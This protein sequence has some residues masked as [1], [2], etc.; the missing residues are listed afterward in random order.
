MSQGMDP[1]TDARQRFDV[2]FYLVAI[3]FLL[4]D[5][6]LFFFYPWAVAQWECECCGGGR[7]GAGR[8]SGRG[9]AVWFSG[10]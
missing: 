1:A 6:E 2:R 7:D 9:F 5:V 3:I 8:N 4:F 10:R